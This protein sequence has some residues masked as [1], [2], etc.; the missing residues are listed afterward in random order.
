MN[1]DQI[2]KVSTLNKELLLG[3][4]AGGAILFQGECLRKDTALREEIKE[5]L[6]AATS[7]N[8]ESDV[9]GE[10]DMGVVEARGRQFLWRIR[11]FNNHMNGYSAKPWDP[12]QV[13]RIL[14]VVP[15]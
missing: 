3:E 1:I 15:I 8:A 5:S 13:R 6:R 12:M 9:F 4:A 2:R 10:L 14:Y 11:Y 7:S